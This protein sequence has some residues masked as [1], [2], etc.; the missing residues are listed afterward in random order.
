MNPFTRSQMVAL[1][2]TTRASARRGAPGAGVVARPGAG[3]ACA[4]A[5]GAR[6]DRLGAGTT[7]PAT[8]ANRWS[9]P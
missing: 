3:G 1:D 8:T 2:P 9:G 6:A 4:G 5:A 7:P